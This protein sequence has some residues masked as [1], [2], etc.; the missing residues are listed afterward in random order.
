MPCATDIGHD[1]G[2]GQEEREVERGH[3]RNFRERPAARR[4][5]GA[6]PPLCEHQGRPG[7]RAFEKCGEIEGG[8]PIAET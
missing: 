4:W 7:P 6:P 5:G 8:G 1:R 2:A 3:L